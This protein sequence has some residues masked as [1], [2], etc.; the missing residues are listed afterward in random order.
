MH[1]TETKNN[2]YNQSDVID[3]SMCYMYDRIA[4]NYAVQ[5]NCMAI[6]AMNTRPVCSG[7]D[8]HVTMLSHHFISVP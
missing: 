2:A 6:I 7:N 1:T 5:S 3:A 8:I 4:R